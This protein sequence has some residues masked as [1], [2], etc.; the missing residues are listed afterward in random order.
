V[1]PEE[2][3]DCG[4]RLLDSGGVTFRRG[5]CSSGRQVALLYV[6]WSDQSGGPHHLHPS[7]LKIL[8]NAMTSEMAI[9]RARFQP[10]RGCLRP[11][12]VGMPL[13]ALTPA[14]VRMKAW[15]SG[16]MASI[17][18]ILPSAARRPKAGSWC[19]SIALAARGC[20][21][22]QH[23]SPAHAQPRRASAIRPHI[24]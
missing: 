4:V 20:T 14:P 19:G 6:K 17:M 15:S 9:F 3:I 12:K 5:R 16:A 11:R 8:F 1:S 2:P 24:C 13:S 22:R 18:R 23:I 21:S 10:L 7:V